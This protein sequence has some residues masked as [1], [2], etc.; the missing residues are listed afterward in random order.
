MWRSREALVWTLTFTL[1]GYA[2]SDSFTDAG[3][4]ATRVT[5]IAVLL[6]TAAFA[7]RARRTRR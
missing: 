3:D 6:A 2:F 5:L 4:T 7:I 1:I